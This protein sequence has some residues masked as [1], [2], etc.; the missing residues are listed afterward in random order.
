MRS[1]KKIKQFLTLVLLGV[2][3]FSCQKETIKKTQPAL[4]SETDVSVELATSVAK[5]FAYDQAVSKQ[6]KRSIEKSAFRANDFKSEQKVKKV[7]SIKS[8]EQLP[9]FYIVNL[10]PEG[11]VLVS[12]NKKEAPILAFSETGYFEYDSLSIKSIGLFDWIEA[13]KNRIKE[14]RNNPSIDVVD[15]IEK[16]WDYMAPPEGDD[17]EVIISG[18]TVYQQVGPLLNT[19]WNQGCGYN[20]LLASCSSGGSCSRV[21]AGCVA[22]ATAQVMRYWQHPSSYTWS[23]MPNNSGSNE[24][25]RLMKDIGDAVDMNYD[26]S[27]S[28]ASTEDARDALVN[29]FG[30]SSGAQYVYV[31]S[32]VV[33]TQLNYH[34]PLIMRGEGSGG[35]AFVCEGYRRNRH[36]V[37]HNPGTYYEYETSIISDFYLWMNWDGGIT[38]WLVSL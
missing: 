36:I 30:Y 13:R 4:L 17:D 25:S 12:G 28:G 1:I 22:T 27:G 14:L 19:T 37:I 7:V 24:T 16:Q 15:R 33:V 34:Y 11:F 18:G 29:E 2:F 31:H 8:A 35:H 23:A 3:L 38:R 10:E 32:D 20:N 6:L 26:C 9:A 21:W 5:N